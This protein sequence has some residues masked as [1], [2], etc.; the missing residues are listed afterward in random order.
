LK[1]AL[2]T[3]S[4]AG[5]RQDN[6]VFYPYMK[7]FY[8]EIFFPIIDEQNIKTVFHL[9]DIVDRRKYLNFVTANHLRT[10]F[11]FPLLKR[12]I[13]T[14]LIAGNH[15]C[16]YKNTNR[17][18]VYRE[19]SLNQYKN[20]TVY[21]KPKTITLDGIEILLL[22]W[23]C[24]E[25]QEESLEL[26]KNTKAKLCFGHL[27]INGFSMN[28]GIVAHDGLDKKTF[29]NFDMVFS[30]HFHTRQSMDNITYLGSPFQCDWGD[31]GHVG[32]FHIFDTETKELEFFPNK[33]DLFK[34]VWYDDKDKEHN[35]ILDHNFDQYT[36][37]F[38]KVIITD[39]TNPYLFDQFMV[40]M[41]AVAEDV[42]PVEDHLNLDE[43]KDEEIFEDVEDTLTLLR[44]SIDMLPNTVPKADMNKEMESIYI[45]ARDLR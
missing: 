44:N 39:K 21:T 31:Y 30:G 6:Q 38:C 11:I 36:G 42:K 17:V 29:S 12:N 22:P 13:D 20:I 14:H 18:N 45:E 8:D 40:K 15:D 16:Y 9:G 5:T 4:H 28:T 1:I 7:K 41:E 35:E 43:L 19:L 26:I 24:N 37:C 25:T 2:I 32:G 23:I 33:F 27:N 3:D 10:D 34:K